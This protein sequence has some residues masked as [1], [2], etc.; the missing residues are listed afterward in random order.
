[1]QFVGE[2]QLAHEVGHEMHDCEDALAYDLI[3][4]FG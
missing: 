3:G 4:Q 1:M 2:L